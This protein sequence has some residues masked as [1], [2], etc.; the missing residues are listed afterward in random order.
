MSPKVIYTLQKLIYAPQHCHFWL[1]VSKSHNRSHRYADEILET[2]ASETISEIIKAGKRK[3]I[4]EGYNEGVRKK[5]LYILVF[6]TAIG[7]T[8]WLILYRPANKAV[9]PG[10]QSTPQPT[11]TPLQDISFNKQLHAIN[12]PDSIWWVVSKVRPLDPARYAP[13]DLVVPDIPL[14]AGAGDSEMR[15]RKEAASALEQLVQAAKQDK[16]SLMLASGYRSYQLQVAVYNANVQKYGQAGADKQSARPGTSEH[17]TGLAADIEPASRQ[18]E[19]EQCFGDLEEGK[20]LSANAYKWGFV[21]RYP[22]DKDNITGYEYEPW[23]IRYVGTELSIELH[24]QN[25][26][27]LEEFFGIIPTKQ[28]Y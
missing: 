4:Y 22:L 1:K 9:A 17:Q 6:L 16:I 18:C 27:T 19:I 5:L 10:Q 7:L 8:I 21:I 20:W 23:H 12:E 28:P 26:Q 3:S 13:V 14:R 11:V 25:T 15:L 2:F 24:K